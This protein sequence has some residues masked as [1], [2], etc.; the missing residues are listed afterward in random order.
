MRLEQGFEG[1]VQPGRAGQPAGFTGQSQEV[2]RFISRGT[3]SVKHLKSF[4]VGG[5]TGKQMSW[6]QKAQVRVSQTVP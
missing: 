5:A 3:A 1:A 6:A 2:R 4:P